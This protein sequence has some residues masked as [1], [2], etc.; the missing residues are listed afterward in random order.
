MSGPTLSAVDATENK[1][2]KKKKILPGMV[3]PLNRD[4]RKLQQGGTI[5]AEGQRGGL[6][7]TR[8]MRP[9]D[10]VAQG[11]MYW[12]C[13]CVCVCTCVLSSFSSLQLCPALH[14]HRAHSLPGSCVHGVPQARILE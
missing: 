8:S 1:M 3:G 4:E 7:R 5:R 14:D 10:G 6:G 9:G 11:C 13:V 2:E 12:P